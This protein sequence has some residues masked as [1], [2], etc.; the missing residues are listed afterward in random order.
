MGIRA[1]EITDIFQVSHFITRAGLDE[2]GSWLI[3]SRK[4]FHVLLKT[5]PSPGKDLKT[6]KRH[7]PY[8]ITFIY[9]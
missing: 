9:S 8:R 1:L 6:V 3:Q 5:S 7:I 4:L 2:K